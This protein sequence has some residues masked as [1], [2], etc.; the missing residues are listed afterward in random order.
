MRQVGP[1]EAGLDCTEIE[2]DH[3]VKTQVAPYSGA[4]V[5]RRRR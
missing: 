3:L 2:V 1:G 4:V 5:T